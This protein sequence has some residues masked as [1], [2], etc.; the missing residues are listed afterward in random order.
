MTHGMNVDMADVS[1]KAKLEAG[2]SVGSHVKV[3][4]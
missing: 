2:R 4:F 3:V 1:P